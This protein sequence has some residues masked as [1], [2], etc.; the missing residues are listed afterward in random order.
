MHTVS[1]PATA[2]FVQHVQA[3]TALRA[4]LATAPTLDALQR[5]A[6]ELGRARL[7]LPSLAWTAADDPVDRAQ[8]QA[9]VGDGLGSLTLATDAGEDDR[10]LL[11]LYATLLGLLAGR[12]ACSPE[13]VQHRAIVGNMCDVVCLIDSYGLIGHASRNVTR[14]FGW[15]PVEMVGADPWSFLHPD[16]R[17]AV[18]QRNTEILDRPGAAVTVECRLRCRDGQYRD[19]ELTIVNLHHDP[20]LRG[21]LVNYHDITAR[22]AAESALSEAARR[23]QILIEQSPDGILVIDPQTTGFL[24]FNLAAHRM[25]GYTAEEFARLRVID[26]EC[27]ESAAEIATHIAAI[28]RNGAPVEFDTTLR[29]RDGTPRHIQVA[30]QF[31]DVEGQTIY[32]CTW[33]DITERVES[34]AALQRQEAYLRA[35][36]QTTADGFMIVDHEGRILDVNDAMCALTGYARDALLDMRVHDLD[37]QES[38]DETRARAQRSIAHGAELF[39]TRYR[40]KDGAVIDVEVSFSYLA[41][42]GGRFIAFFRDITER[43]RRDE[44]LQVQAEL[45]DLAP[46]AIFVFNT[47][48]R[49]YYANQASWIMHGYT[50]EE[51]MALTLRDINAPESAAL[52]TAR[53]KQI[54]T[55]GQAAFEVE[56]QCKDGS[57]LPL[58]IFVKTVSWQGQPAML[59]IAADLREIKQAEAALRESHALLT[60][61]LRHSPV[62]AFIKEV[63]PTESRVLVAS[64]NY[65]NMIGIPAA[66]M[67][68]KPMDELFPPAFAAKITA[69][70]WAVAS[71]GQVLQLD[72]DLNDRHYTTIKFP[73][74]LGGRTLLAGYT[75]DIT[76]RQ[77]SLE[78]RERLQGQLAQAQKLESIGRLAGG[79][80]HD[81]NNMLGVILGYADLALLQTR[82]GLPLHEELAEIQ[83]AATRS[84]ELTRQLLAFAR[85]QTVTPQTLDMNATITGTLKMLRRLIGEAIRLVWQPDPALWP[86][87]LDPAQVD[88]LLANLCVNAR[89]AID[90]T[91]EVVIATANIALDAAFCAGCADARVGDY[92]RLAVR[93]T[94]RGMD[95]ATQAHIFEPFFTT[96]D[97]GLGTGLGLATVYG[98]V[99]QHSG[100]ITVESTPGQ[101]TTFTVYLPR[102]TIALSAAET[103]AATPALAPGRECVLVVEDEPAII[104]LVEIAL[105]QQGYRVLVAT[106]P[107]EALAL[108][109]TAG[110][111]IHLLLTDVIMPGMNGRE[112]AERLRARFPALHC[113]FMSG[114]TADILAPS[115]VDGDM[116]FLQKPFTLYDLAARVRQTLDG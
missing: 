89:D 34:T 110:A 71:S 48:G 112:L 37:I 19:I 70:D 99:Q 92:V 72:E 109:E 3:L 45:L 26:V 78:E 104:K 5:R 39:E 27:T 7:E 10:T 114:Y 32:Q 4:S 56:H 113:L 84:S 55:H 61:F 21:V 52:L 97:A 51:F 107:E 105:A 22:K 83:Q 23:R 43:K 2:V 8:P 75:I 67:I 15:Q 42:D 62:Y 12:F 100:F 77:R 20:Q 88:Q 24:E 79:V 82:P 108:V 96:K 103:S 87:F 38:P 65:V 53:K 46:N 1:T 60:T 14:L 101:G 58:H 91:G 30:A 74:A 68:G 16:D 85:K 29:A 49:L 47:E 44:R 69:D 86:V 9:A 54:L 63:T 11:A 95:A 35:I 90:G 59:S 41:A 81:F 64:D 40:R 25:L 111:E 98:I 33:R 76:E 73:I 36:L 18:R 31:L 28:E 13:D 102:D 6:V 57:R 66:Q 50:P 94:G 115:G 93:D 17:L 116:P 80:A 106:S